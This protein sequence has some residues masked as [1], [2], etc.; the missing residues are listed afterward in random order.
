M[1][2]VDLFIQRLQE[3]V[4]SP[5][6]SGVAAEKP[7]NLTLWYNYCTFDIIGDLA[8]GEPFGCLEEGNY[9]PWVR[10]IFQMVRLGVVFQ[11]ANYFS[12]LKSFITA[13]MSTKSMTERR[14]EHLDMTMQKLKRRIELGKN[15]PRTDLMEGLLKKKDEWVS[16]CLLWKQSRLPFLVNGMG[17][18]ADWRQFLF[19]RITRWNS[20][21]ATPAFS[22]SPAPRRQR[23]FFRAPR[24][25]S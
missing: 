17:M 10:T 15:E 18:N 25:C 5:Y 9:H 11:I 22:S 2:Y 19:G 14:M 7:V 8:F 6:S 13:V 1:K 16:C 23:R 12:A 4:T 21:R 3:Q 20:L 24:T